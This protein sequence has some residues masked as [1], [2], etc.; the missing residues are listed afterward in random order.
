LNWQKFGLYSTGPSIGAK[1]QLITVQLLTISPASTDMA[2]NAAGA[3]PVDRTNSL[4]I[5]PTTGLA[6]ST[7]TNSLSV[8]STDAFLSTCSPATLALHADHSLRL[9]PDVAPPLHVSTTFWYPSDPDALIPAA[10]ADHPY[11]PAP[12]AHVYSRHS[13]PNASRLESL[14]AALLGAP[15]LTYSSGLAATHALYTL[16]R[17]RRVF[18]TGGYHGVHGVLAVLHRVTGGTHY[19]APPLEEAQAQ[20]GAG[21]V[22]H[23]ETPVNP[24]G[25]VRDLA[26]YAAL[27][28]ERRAFLVVDGTLAPPPLQDPFAQGV[29]A[30][31][32]SATKYLGGHS[33]L[34]LGIIATRRHDWMANLVRDRIVLGAV[35]GSMESWLAARSVRTLGARIARQSAAAGKLVAWLH[36]ALDSKHPIPGPAAAQ[37]PEI[38]PAQSQALRVVLARVQHSSVQAAADKTVAAWLSQQMPSGGGSPVF[39]VS[40]TQERF[41]RHLP[42]HL[43]LFAHATSLGGVESLIEWRAMSD[44]TV[45]RCVLRVSVGLE[46]AEDLWRDFVQACEALAKEK[47]VE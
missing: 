46:D 42:G 12:E 5:N 24:T 44:T 33:D 34:L 19:S 10:D 4:P 39:A 30:V 45:D 8:S 28:K 18:I 1:H 27:A 29:D 11:P 17:P 47:R 13:S 2:A 21:D 43:H 25:E 15:S 36:N 26:S 16:L 35:P 37:V 20:C 9:N 23:V 6:D 40:T 38:S 14:L 7:L 3:L 31:I 32:H 41:A 22:L